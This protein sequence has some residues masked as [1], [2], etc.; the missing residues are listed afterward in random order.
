MHACMHLLGGED[1]TRYE[2]PFCSFLPTAPFPFC[3]L[4]A[5]FL[6]PS[7][8]ADKLLLDKM[9]V[10]RSCFRRN[11]FYPSHILRTNLCEAKLAG[12]QA[13]VQ[14]QP[15][16][17]RDVSKRPSSVHQQDRNIHTVQSLCKC[18]S[19][20]FLKITCVSS[21]PERRLGISAS[22]PITTVSQ[23]FPADPHA[24]EPQ[25]FEETSF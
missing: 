12:S 25:L 20:P 7:T 10:L 5:S 6:P 16:S 3:R 23:R 21:T 18:Q 9:K 4:G 22:A 24:K 15:S 11:I 19:S 1:A 13:S 8:N 14:L 2:S 17:R